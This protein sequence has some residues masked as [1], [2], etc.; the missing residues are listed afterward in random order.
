LKEAQAVG[1]IGNWEFDLQ[2]QNIEWSD[3]VYKLYGSDKALGPPSPEEEA[4]YYSSEQAEELRRFAHIVVETKKDMK[5]DVTAKLS[6]GR[7][8]FFSC[9]MYPIIDRVRQRQLGSLEI[10]TSKTWR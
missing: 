4:C 10:I 5:Y 9:T 3:E 8:A 2:T 1:R 7:T 6:S